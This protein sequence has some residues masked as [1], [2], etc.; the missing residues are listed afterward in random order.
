[1]PFAPEQICRDRSRSKQRRRPHCDIRCAQCGRE[2]AVQRRLRRHAGQPHADQDQH[3]GERFGHHRRLE[4]HDPDRIPADGGHRSGDAHRHAA[5]PLDENEKR[6]SRCDHRQHMLRGLHGP[7]VLNGLQAPEVVR[8][9]RTA[10]VV[11]QDLARPFERRLI[12]RRVAAQR[13][14]EIEEQRVTGRSRGVVAG[15]QL[16]AIVPLIVRGR[17]S[18]PLARDGQIAVRI[19]WKN[20]LMAAIPRHPW[21]CREHQHQNQAASECQDWH[22]SAKSPLPTS[23][24]SCTF[25][26][27]RWRYGTTFRPSCAPADT[28][29]SGSTDPNRTRAP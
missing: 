2:S 27:G 15:R 9:R 26:P 20:R 12:G 4:R 6:E 28:F 24:S 3:A 5:R 14:H 16:G 8:P 1:M 25:R 18:A 22:R 7:Y 19:R 11:C 10:L 23:S 29:P 17:L 13:E 21:Q